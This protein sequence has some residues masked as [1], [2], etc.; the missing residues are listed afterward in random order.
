MKALAWVLACLMWS[1]VLVGTVVNA[2]LSSPWWVAACWLAVA[3]LSVRTLYRLGHP[4][5]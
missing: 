4:D 1:I 5:V 3:G 2:V